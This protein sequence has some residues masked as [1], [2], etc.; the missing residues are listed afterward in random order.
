ML[1]HIAGFE[2]RTTRNSFVGLT[3]GLDWRNYKMLD[4]RWVKDGD[5]TFVTSFP[6][7]AD[8]TYS[9]LR[10][11][12]LTL[13]FMY[14]YNFNRYVN[15][16]IGPVVSFNTRGRIKTRFALEGELVKEKL[17]DINITPVTVDFK[18]ELN[19]RF[20]G[21]YF[22]YSPCN[23]FNTNFGPAFKPMSAGLQFSF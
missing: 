7:G 20:V 12:S 4:Q 22:K 23:V 11:L 6:D 17:K 10:T 9:R 19:F 8:I 21:L 2:Y 5:N 16:K 13:S 3:F 1:D 14:G 18:A 15:M